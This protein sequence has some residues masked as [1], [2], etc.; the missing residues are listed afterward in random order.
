MVTA[1][2]TRKPV[3]SSDATRAAWTAA[4]VVICF[5]AAGTLAAQVDP[6]LAGHTPPHPALRGTL[7]EAAG[8]L[9]NN[10]RVLLVPFALC[11]TGAAR[12]ALTRR[13]GD[14]VLVALTAASTFHVGVALGRW[15]T[16]L[17]PYVPQLPVEWAALILALATWRLACRRTVPA[18]ELLRL[19]GVCAVL[20]TAAA[21]L[22]T[23]AT[24]HRAIPRTQHCTVTVRFRSPPKT[25]EPA[26]IADAS[27]IAPG[28]PGRCKVARSLP[29]APLG[30]AR[31]HPAHIE[32]CQSP[33][34]PQGGTS[35]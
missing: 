8:I 19:A 2:L 16:R 7:G 35:R 26:V 17:V 11:L 3:I 33:P 13:A 25:G 10:L 30:S 9:V 21:G 29:L 18:A 12:P 32:L 6:R 15:Q 31:P 28:R 5:T 20:L 24:P 4:A 34:D 14:L 27:S 1:E 23:W 22:E